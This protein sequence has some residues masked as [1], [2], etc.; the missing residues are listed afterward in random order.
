[1]KKH[2][3]TKNE[4]KN[5][6]ILK[7]KR[8]KKRKIVKEKRNKK[9]KTKLPIHKR[10]CSL[11]LKQNFVRF[12]FLKKKLEKLFFLLNSKKCY[13]GSTNLVT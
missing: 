7:I 11:F 12:F 5:R 8:K 3:R 2:V 6:Y 10:W 1:M 13:I 9:K 4:T